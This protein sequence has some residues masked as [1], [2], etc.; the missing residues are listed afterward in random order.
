M[1][2]W[3]PS[4]FNDPDWL[5]EVKWDGYR[6][7]AVVRDGTARL[8]T[9]RRQDAGHYFPALAGDAPWIE[10]REAIVDGEVV[11]LDESGRPRFSL[12]QDRTGI[13][14]W[15]APG[16]G[17]EGEP[18]PIVYEV[19]DLLHL[20]GRSLVDVPLEERKRLLEGPPATAPPR[21][22]R[23]PRGG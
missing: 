7:E 14:T 17:K 20:D 21:P 11:A 2:P 12:L 3:R 6:V 22:L 9:R 18:A 1:P 13:R 5:F 16:T 4:P 23:E 8:W 10:A 15:R 19:F